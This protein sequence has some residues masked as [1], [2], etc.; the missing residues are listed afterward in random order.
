MNEENKEF[1]EK[2]TSSFKLSKMS[3]GYNWEIKIYSDDLIE[4][5]NKIMEMDLWAV[6]NYGGSE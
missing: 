2:Q 3:K 4:L 1:V 5:Q 6:K